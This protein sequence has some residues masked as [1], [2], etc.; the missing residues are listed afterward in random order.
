MSDNLKIAVVGA[1][2]IARE[3]IKVIQALG[4]QA[5]VIGRGEKNIAEVKSA[6]PGVTAI[7][8]G[9]E[10]WLESN[11]PP[12]HAIVATPID[13]LA[14]VTKQLLQEGCKR[15]LVEKPLTYSVEEAKEIA[16]LAT[17]SHAE[18]C[19]AFNRRSYVSVTKALELIKADGGVSSFHFDFT[20]AVFRIDPSNYSK[21]TNK[22]WGIANSSHVID[23]AFFLGGKP[24]R[25]EC[26]Q[27]GNAIDWHPA[28]STF[29]GMGETE[30][31]VPFTYHSNW[32][33]P[34]KWN[35]AIMTPERKL[36]F[37]P[38]EQLHQQLKGS[39]KVELVD[40]DYSPDKDYKPGF[41]EQVKRWLDEDSYLMSADKLSDELENLN[42]IFN[43]A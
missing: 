14:N 39:F 13:H 16:R 27:Y 18:V 4:H 8:G 43:Y 25:M 32:G 40:I 3:Y 9:L 24:A 29:T 37:S 30:T 23:T 38:M 10:H 11:K 1:G 7:S 19:I 21:E 2:G 33:C 42:S 20:E 28:G 26:R 15:I 17:E 35:I 6:F 41:L 34:G 31:G 22:L 5:L 12:E 36:L